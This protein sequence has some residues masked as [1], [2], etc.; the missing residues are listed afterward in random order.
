M[1]LQ[2]K[3]PKPPSF[4]KIKKS[5]S[6]MLDDHQD[7]TDK[8]D[9]LRRMTN[10]YACRDDADKDLKYFYKEIH[11]LD[12]NLRMHINIEN[13]VLFKKARIME[14]KMLSN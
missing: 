14:T 4:G 10:D 3:L 8:L 9:E 5:V 11:S 13:N 12:K 6:G 2:G 1:V 7:S